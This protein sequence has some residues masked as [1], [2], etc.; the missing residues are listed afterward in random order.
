VID[1]AA[2]DAIDVHVHTELTHVPLLIR[3]PGGE[4]GGRRIT[5]SVGTLDVAATVLD[6]LGL[7][8]DIGGQSF[9]GLLHGDAAADRPAYSYRDGYDTILRSVIVGGWHYIEASSGAVELYHLPEDPGETEDRMA[10]SPAAL[11][12]RLRS[13]LLR[14]F[15]EEARIAIRSAR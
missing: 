15:G 11:V 14:G 8:G 7:R 4:G 3:L 9:A 2:I 12:A 1:V 5:S 6:E 10:T 13:R